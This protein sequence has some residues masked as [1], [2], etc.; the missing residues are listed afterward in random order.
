MPSLFLS[1]GTPTL[2]LTDSP[3]RT[4]LAQLGEA[5]EQPK[6]ILVV[7]AHWETVQPT[8]NAVSRNET[9]HDFYGFPRSLYALH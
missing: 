2:P 6:A 8:V 9:I 3:A 4:F 7:S 5:L 1:H